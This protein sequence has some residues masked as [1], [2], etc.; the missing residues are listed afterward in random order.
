MVKGQAQ[1]V[2]ASELERILRIGLGRAILFLRSN[3]A[4][5][6]RDAI[7]SACVHCSTYDH[8]SE[9]SRVQYLRDIIRETKE[10]VLYRTEITSALPASSHDDDMEQL[11]DLALAF[12]KEGDERARRAMYAKFAENAAQGIT[13][14]A[15]QLIEL[16]KAEGLLFITERFGEY[17]Q[18]DDKFWDDRGLI[19][20]AEEQVGAERLQ[21]TLQLARSRNAQIAKYLEVVEK[22]EQRA[23][24]YLESDRFDLTS[25][26]YDELKQHITEHTATDQ[27]FL[28]GR[29]GEKADDESI[30]RAA[31]DLLEQD[32]N[33]PLLSYVRIFSRRTFPLNPGRLISLARH[34]D[35]EIAS[36]ALRALSN[37]GHPEVR[38]LGLE[39]LNISPVPNFATALLIKNCQS[40]DH[41]LVAH[42]IE[43]ERQDVDALHS[44]GLWTRDI[45]EANP[46]PEW[47]DVLLTIYEHGPCSLC[48]MHFI[49]LLRS[50]GNL[51]NWVIQECLCDANL[52]LRGKA[53]SYRSNE[54]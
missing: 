29:W 2:Q 34:P 51:P 16:D 31:R 18:A 42:V 43:R 23:A 12:A 13:T 6:Y 3:D 48:R 40:G 19:R 7:L 32:S 47:S 21:A 39:L 30:E 49:D 41:E 9:G 20:L 36:A 4:R 35:E 25:L 50:L 14:G 33:G 24:A 1:V 45:V 17:A 28:L 27:R 54:L 11:F 37:V 22:T 53:Q 26:S 52:E 10:E 38:K 46:T 44:L 15:W 8:Q 5:P